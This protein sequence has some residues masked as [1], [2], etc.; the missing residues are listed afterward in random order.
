[1]PSDLAARLD[2]AEQAVVT[3]R[4]AL[5]LVASD[6]VALGGSAFRQSIAQAALAAIDER[7]ATP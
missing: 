3:L 1:M 5:K 4:V 2:R 7:T 6:G